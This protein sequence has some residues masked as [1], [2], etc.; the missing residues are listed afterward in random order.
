MEQILIN[1]L[2]GL[3]LG[4]QILLVKQ[5]ALIKGK[6]SI[7]TVVGN[8]AIDNVI[9]MSKASLCAIMHHKVDPFLRWGIEHE[10]VE[11]GTHQLVKFINIDI[12]SCSTC[13][14]KA[15]L[16]PIFSLFLRSCSIKSLPI[17]QCS[18]RLTYYR[19][20]DYFKTSMVQFHDTLFLRSDM[21]SSMSSISQ[22]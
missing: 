3:Q 9:V 4:Y 2:V 17:I 11:R 8:R 13:F 18:I 20:F 21:Y 12:P 16:H 5:P 10:A 7:D 19:L 22:W 14:F 1:E 6:S 15:T